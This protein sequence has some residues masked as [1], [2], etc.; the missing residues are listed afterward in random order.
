DDVN[1]V[2]VQPTIFHRSV[3]TLVESALPGVPGQNSEHEHTDNHVKG[4]HTRHGE[5]KREKYLC[6][7]RIHGMPVQLDFA[8]LKV[9]TGEVVFLEFCRPF[10]AL[11]TQKS[12]AK[13]Q[14]QNEQHDQQC[15]FAHLRGAHPKSNGQ[16][17]ADENDCIYGSQ[18]DIQG[19][20][21]SCEF[22]EVPASVNQI[23]AEHA[24]EKHNFG[25]QEEPHAERC[26]VTLL[27][28]IGEM[29]P[30]FRAVSLFHSYWTIAQASPLA[31]WAYFRNRT[32]PS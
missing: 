3:I 12:Q 17:A 29:V 4:V 5:I 18:P 15:A 30:Q 31:A 27:L 10:D 25:I 32:P 16:A 19:L 28:R 24:P 7:A 11:D 1:E 21:R 14:R 23:R 9:R 8:G 13:D 6:A 20:A 2:P 26:G 22:G